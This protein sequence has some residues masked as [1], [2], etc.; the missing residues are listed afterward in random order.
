MLKMH[1]F[2]KYIPK[3]YLKCKTFGSYK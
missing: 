3:L 1:F 2:Y